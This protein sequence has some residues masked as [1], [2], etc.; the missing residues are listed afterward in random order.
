VARTLT[1]LAKYRDCQ[2]LIVGA[3]NAGGDFAGLLDRNGA[4]V[5]LAMKRR[6]SGVGGP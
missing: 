3:A 6:L 4:H 2:V 5:T 1:T